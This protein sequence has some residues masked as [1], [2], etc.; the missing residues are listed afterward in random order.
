M[1]LVVAYSLYFSFSIR[2]SVTARVISSRAKASH[3]SLPFVCC[4]TATAS[5]IVPGMHDAQILN[6]YLPLLAINN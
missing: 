6:R 1:G 3:D 2:R 5:L 4:V